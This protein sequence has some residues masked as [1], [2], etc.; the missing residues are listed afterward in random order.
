MKRSHT[1]SEKIHT[2]CRWPERHTNKLNYEKSLHISGTNTRAKFK[3][4]EKNLDDI[5]ERKGEKTT[6]KLSPSSSAVPKLGSNN[7]LPL[8]RKNRGDKIVGGG[9]FTNK[10]KRVLLPLSHRNSQNERMRKTYI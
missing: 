1:I 10:G 2:P 3:N 5:Q 7:K 9:R 4:L 8:H 6:A